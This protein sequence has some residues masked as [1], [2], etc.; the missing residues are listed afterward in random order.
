MKQG[1]V[2]FHMGCRFH[3]GEI[4]DKLFIILNTPRQNEFFITCKTTSQQKWRLKKEGC[5]SNDNYYVLRENVDYFNKWTWVQFQDYYPISQELLQRYIDRGI[6]TKKADLREQTIRAIN[7]CV[8]N[9]DDIS[10]LYISM[11]NR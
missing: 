4:G 5:N 11:I 7:N 1:T 6:I 2:Y 9:S 10:P 3:D 8:C